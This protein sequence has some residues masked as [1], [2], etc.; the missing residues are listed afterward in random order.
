[1]CDHRQALA[2]SGGIM[3]GSSFSSD[4]SSSSYSSFDDDD[5]DDDYSSISSSNEVN[6]SDSEALGAFLTI[7]LL[8]SIIIWLINTP[9]TSVVKLQI[10]SL[11]TGRSLQKDLNRIAEWVDTSTSK[12]FNYVLQE[13]ILALLRHSDCYISGYSSVDLKRNVEE[14]EKRFNQLSVEERGKFDEKTLVN[15]NNVKNKSATTQ[16]SNEL[17]NEYIVVSAFDMVTIIVAVRD[18]LK[19][20]SFKSS[21]EL[22]KVLQMLASVHSS[23]IMGAERKMILLRRKKCLKIIPCCALFS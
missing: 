11:G 9:T 15:V 21:A 2:D 7:F 18:I 12:G 20:P 5:D 23:N 19:L 16:S 6:P 3:G 13:T 14:C 10:G 8:F 22:K 1:M 17:R 4:S